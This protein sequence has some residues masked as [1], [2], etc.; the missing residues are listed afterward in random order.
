MLI[1]ATVLR[2]RARGPRRRRA[3][4]DTRKATVPPSTTQGLP[5]RGQAARRPVAAEA[6]GRCHTWRRGAARRRWI[7]GKNAR[8]GF[9]Q[10][11][12]LG[13]NVLVPQR[14]VKTDTFWP[15]GA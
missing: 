8:R 3:A 9:I 7:G 13:R 14:A 15:P 4:A 2:R 1:S 5:R 10:I 6:A 12:R 11:H